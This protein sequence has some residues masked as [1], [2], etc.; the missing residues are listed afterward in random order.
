MVV[1]VEGSVDANEVLSSAEKLRTDSRYDHKFMA[2]WDFR[3]IEAL[4]G[5]DEIQQVLEGLSKLPNQPPVKSALLVDT[6]RTTALATLYS[7]LA[8][9]I[10]QSKPFS[11][12]KA[13]GEWLGRDL[14]AHLQDKIQ[15]L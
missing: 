11:T 12:V 14:S 9:Q 2:V 6:R 3:A 7:E 1:K 13:A 5:L 4:Y 10:H 8:T 15:D